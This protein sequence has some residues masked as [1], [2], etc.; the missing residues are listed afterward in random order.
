M[1]GLV[2][3]GGGAKG[4]YQIGAYQ[5]LQELEISIEGVAGTSIGAINAA[6]IAQGSFTEAREIWYNL[7]PERIFNVSSEE[8]QQIFNLDI[9][10]NNLSKIVA[11]V[12]G[13]LE[14]RGIDT[15]GIRDFLAEHIDEDKLR[16]SSMD[17]G[18]VTYN[19]TD[20]QPEELYL[21]DIPPG[22]LVDYLMAS[23]YLPVFKFEK[24]NG[25]F[26]LDGA[27][28]DNLP[29]NLLIRRGYQEIIAVRTFSSGRIRPPEDDSVAITYIEP[30][31]DLGR[32]LEFT[33]DRI[34]RNIRYGYLDTMKVFCNL[35]GRNYYIE[36]RQSERFFFNLF[37]LIRE[38][39]IRKA[40]KLLGLKQQP[41]KRLLFEK[42]IPRLQN[43]LEL[44]DDVGYREIII[45][46]CE[47][48]AARLEIPA[49]E[50]YEFTELV[51]KIAASFDPELKDDLRKI[52][53]FL[54]QSQLFSLI[55][56]DDLALELIITLFSGMFAA[57]EKEK[58]I[59]QYISKSNS[60]VS[61][62]NSRN[63]SKNKF[64]DKF[65]NE[66]NNFDNED[67]NFEN[68]LDKV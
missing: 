1:P 39:D 14:N 32:V 51:R 19:L 36:T 23:S 40:A 48:L 49:D 3:E 25:K 6:M 24:M 35:A 16:Q 29:V 66:D 18:I 60:G 62:R 50:I 53:G 15:S 42:I 11:R 28:H 5:A 17:L 58:Y 27:V 37:H 13:I 31:I 22:M 56:R 8:L 55:V 26:F 45:G 68:K 2:L 46:V 41:E 54:K 7:E 4:A 65:D 34:D 21:E 43:L 12:R 52:P 59:S 57:E 47:V 10:R 9:D 38:E 44:E 64:A 20:F 30:D 67:N 61:K 63:N 33:P